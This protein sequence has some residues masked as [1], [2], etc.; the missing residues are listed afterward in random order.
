MRLAQK[1]CILLVAV[2]GIVSSSMFAA[3]VEATYEEELDTT[4]HNSSDFG[5]QDQ[6]FAVALHVGIMTIYT[7]GNGS[8][9]GLYS[10]RIN[11]SGNFGGG[12]EYWLLSSKVINWQTRFGAQLIA[13]T[14]FGNTTIVKTINWAS[15]LDP[16]LGTT[17]FSPSNN[18][19][20]TIQFYLGIRNITNAAQALG[21]GFQFEN[22]SN[23]NL[24]NFTIQYRNN[25]N[26]GTYKDIPFLEGYI[27]LPFFTINY[28]DGSQD[29]LNG[30]T[31]DHT[32]YV[33]L[34]IEQ[35]IFE[36][37]INLINAS[38]TSKA[39]VG[40]VRLTLSGYNS[41]SAQGVSLTFSDGNGSTNTDFRLKHNEIPSFIPFSLYLAGVKV[42]NG[43]A[44]EWPNLVYGNTNLKDLEVGNIIY[45]NA[46]STMGGAYSDTI[47]VNIMSLDSNMIGQ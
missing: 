35:T 45:Q 20:I 6:G 14:S 19:P 4:I 30:N 27:P 8:I 23:I 13:K 25:P 34:T 3:S 43:V 41:P 40:Q 42:N 2:L 29:F 1:I 7:V 21:A 18:Y 39:K 16:L 24:G 15:G 46:I 28:S 36:Q 10:I 44:F 11:R 12:E 47:T 17:S 31:A 37:S 22:G 38:G 32:V 26:T 5:I 33:A 9:P